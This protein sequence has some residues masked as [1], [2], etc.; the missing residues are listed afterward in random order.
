MTQAALPASTLTTAQQQAIAQMED[1]IHARLPRLH[2][3]LLNGVYIDPIGQAVTLDATQ[4]TNAITAL[5]TII[6]NLNT[7]AT[8]L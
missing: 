8:S 7:L 4:T 5:K 3:I 6:A 2:S 1:T